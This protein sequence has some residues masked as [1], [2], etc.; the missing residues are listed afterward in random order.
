MSAEH[1]RPGRQQPCVQ[2][3]RRPP[4]PSE[5]SPP[6]LCSQLQWLHAQTLWGL[7][8]QALRPPAL[9]LQAPFQGVCMQGCAKPCVQCFLN[10]LHDFTCH[11]PC[12][13]PLLARDAII[14]LH[15]SLYSTLTLVYSH[16]SLQRDVSPAPVTTEARASACGTRSGSTDCMQCMRSNV[17]GGMCHGAALA[18]SGA[19]GACIATGA[20]CDEAAAAGAGRLACCMGRG[21]PATRAPIR[22]LLADC[23]ANRDEAS[24]KNA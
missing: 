22:Y 5:P 12:T 24:W 15:Q 9:I 8:L 2:S 18:G 1:G 19:E 17:P 10:T 4:L 16:K 20:G 23:G 14:Q 21:G 13:V 3:R 11:I 6:Q 7:R